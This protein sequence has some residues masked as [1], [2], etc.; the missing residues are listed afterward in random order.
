MKKILLTTGCMLALFLATLPN[1]ASAQGNIF[2]EELWRNVPP[3]ANQTSHVNAWMIPSKSFTGLAY[4]KWRD[5]V[6]IV[7]PHTSVAGPVFWQTP[8]IYA[9]K[10]QTGTPAMDVGRSADAS[11]K[12]LG[13]ELPVPIDTVASAGGVQLYRGYSQNTYSLYKIDLDDEGRIF[14]C[15]LVVPV[16]GICILLPSGQCDPVYLGQGPF[17][18]WRWDTPVAS[19]KC[20]YATLNAG[21]NGIGTGPLDSEMSYHRWGDAF[22]VIGY[23]SMYYPPGEDPY[24][25]DSVRIYTSGGSYPTQ[26]NWNEQVNVILADRRPE[27]QRPSS[28]TG[29]YKLE[30]RLA[31]RLVNSNAGLAAHGVA[32]TSLQ[33]VSDVWMDSNPRI[34]TAATQVQHPTNP[35]PQTYNQQATGNRSLSSSLTGQSGAIRYFELPEYGLKYIV[36]AD[37]YPTGGVD[38]TIPN[39]NTKARIID[40]TTPGQDFQIWG[41]TPQLG[42]KTLNNNSAVENYIADVDFQLK[43][44]SLQ[45]DPDEPGLHVILYV[46]MSNNGIAAF[47]SRKA[48]PVELNTLN[49]TV[50][51]NNVDLVW[52][53]T[54][55][56]NNYGFEIE[57]SFDG[58]ANYENVGFVSGRGTTTAPKDYK[59]SDPITATH[60]NVGNVKY[61]LRQ[62]DNDG[63]ATYSPVVDVYF[64]AQPSTISLYQNYPNPFNPTTTIAYQLTKPGHVTLRVFNSLGENVSTLVNAEKGAG[65][66]QVTMDAANLP[67]GTYIY[68]LNVDGQMQQKKMTVMK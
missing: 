15:N 59:Y 21:S 2:W 1:Q 61:R 12:G 63:T 39:N 10:S 60:R 50:N 25:V 57:R 32:G 7:N 34:T 11:S 3:P 33:L 64:D 68:Q 35:W 6:Y 52:N 67:S 14:A 66:H 55:E 49:A 56:S 22:D 53:V 29:P 37:G 42:N 26:P 13:G 44:Y 40:V 28:D 16:W 18:V 27:A 47:R 19:P 30:Y 20:V 4:D 8:R 51:G 54:S 46:L 38:P 43:H 48:I 36:L 31:I 65:T 62:V 9:W 17:R 23:R 45:E 58:G 24:L 5:V 41:D